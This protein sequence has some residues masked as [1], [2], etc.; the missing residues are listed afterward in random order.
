MSNNLTLFKQVRI[1]DPKSTWNNKICDVLVNSNEIVEINNEINGNYSKTITIEN[2][3]IT[4]GI[5]DIQVNCGAPFDAEKES[6]SSLSNAAIYAGVTDC[7]LMPHPKNPVDSNAQVEF[8]KNSTASLP[9]KFHVAGTISAGL[10]GIDLA[11]LNEMAQSGSIA[12]TDNKDKIQK[13]NLLHLALQYN[14]LTEKLL[15]IH[16]E[17]ASLNLGGQINEGVINVQLG[18]KGIPSIAEELGVVKAIYL[19]N[20]HDASLFL[21]GISTAGSVNLIREAK[22]QGTKIACSVYG[23]QLNLTENDLLDFNSY[24]KVSPP[25]RSQEDKL[26]IIEG[27]SDGT[28]DVICSGHQPEN[29]ETKDVEFEIASIGMATIE[30]LWFLALGLMDNKIELDTI[31]NKLCHEPRRL[32][33]LPEN[34]INKGKIASFFIHTL[35]RNTSFKKSNARSKAVNNPFFDSNF[36]GFIYGTYTNGEWFDNK[37]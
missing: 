21:N 26:A 3:L 11:N 16:A 34:S 23:Y 30:N 2:G 25:L 24:L 1:C 12:F 36:K 22:K 4:P 29:N 27:V 32:L 10:K 8:L 28:I 37:N 5:F 19:S 18:I 13:S 17:D 35:N 33:Q 14:K 15:M 7:L 9:L 6:F 20:Y 31:I